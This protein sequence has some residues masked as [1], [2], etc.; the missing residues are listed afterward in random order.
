VLSH[1]L[2]QRHLVAPDGDRRESAVDQEDGEAVVFQL[3]EEHIDVGVG[4][5]L[6]RRVRRVQIEPEG[7]YFAHGEPDGT[8]REKGCVC[9]SM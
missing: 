3:G 2:L 5:K 8:T 4:N 9:G 1:G 7:A 6:G